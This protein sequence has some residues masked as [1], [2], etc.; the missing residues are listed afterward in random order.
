[1]IDALGRVLKKQSIENER[2]VLA[3]LAQ[4]WPGATVA[5]TKAEGRRLLRS[6][7]A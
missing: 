6:C 4:E 1:V 2:N 7:A 5:M 3:L